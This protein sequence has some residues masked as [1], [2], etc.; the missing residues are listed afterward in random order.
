MVHTMQET[1][2]AAAL[3]LSGGN[4]IVAIVGGGGKSSLLFALARCMPGRIVLTTTTRIFAAQMSLADEVCSLADPHWRKRLDDFASNRLASNLLIV[5]GVDGERAVGVP[6]ELPAQI[7]A[8]PGVDWV[9]VEA[10]GS[11]MRPVKAP[12]AHEPVIPEETG[13]LV[14][15]VGI[16]ALSAPIREVAHRPERVSA[17]VGLTPNEILSPDDLAAL[18]TSRQGGL[19]NAP[20][21]ARVAVLINKV[22]SPRQ[23][24]L[25]RQVAH[26]VLRNPRVE[27]VAIGALGRGSEALWETC[28]R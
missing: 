23:L 17:V 2:V 13:V 21:G 25:A 3:G 10:D 7:V 12:A 9:I 20:H 16:D 27:R 6:P 19:K 15:V 1:S 28:A 5:G 26:S 4:G 11:R 18:L 22:E 14:C 8:R 24:E